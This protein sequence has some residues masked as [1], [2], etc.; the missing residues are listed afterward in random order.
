MLIRQINQNNV[1]FVITGI[2]S[3]KIWVMDNIFAMAT[4]IFCKNQ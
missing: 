1:W 3:I 4:I 2:F